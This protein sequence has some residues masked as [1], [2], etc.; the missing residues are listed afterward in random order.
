MSLDFIRSFFPDEPIQ[1][2]RPIGN[3][4][5]SGNSGTS[6]NT[7][8][9]DSELTSDQLDEAH[10]IA[11]ELFKLH[12]MGIKGAGDPEARFC[13]QLIHQF[14]GTLIESAEKSANRLASRIARNRHTKMR[15]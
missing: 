10:R 13:A 4:G 1:S 7:T 5:I 8:A 6:S 11:R 3:S 2:A 14:G 12:R 15:S 9:A